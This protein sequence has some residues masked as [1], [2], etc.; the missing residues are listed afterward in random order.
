M[1]CYS[2]PEA[3]AAQ[4]C[5]VCG[6]PLCPACAVQVKGSVYCHECLEAR[7]G[8]AAPPVLSS[9]RPEYCSPRVAGWLS[10][11]PGLGLLYL[12]EYLKALVVAFT[13]MGAIQMADHSDA[14]GFLVPLVWVGQ[15]IYAVQEAKRL[16]RLR[17]GQ[18]ETAE[19]PPASGAA[20]DSPVWGGILIVL[21]TL[22]LLDEFDFIRFSEIFAKFWPLLIIGLGI[23]V[24]L[25]GRR[26]DS[27]LAR[28]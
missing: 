5:R 6:H 2:H 27:G 21:G 19:N 24:L 26:R 25:R 7:M 1:N 17:A 4:E 16:N 20:S 11:L 3:E 18:A 14:G 8:N 15:I 22:F 23:Q 10:V 28:P 13:T 9:I 12:R